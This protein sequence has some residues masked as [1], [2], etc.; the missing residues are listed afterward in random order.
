ME[1]TKSGVGHIVNVDRLKGKRIRLNDFNMTSFEEL[2]AT[3][4]A[5]PPENSFGD[6]PLDAPRPPERYVHYHLNPLFLESLMGS[7]EWSHEDAFKLLF[8][9]AVSSELVDDSQN[10]T[11]I[12]NS[13]RL[14]G[15]QAYVTNELWCRLSQV[16]FGVL[17]L[18]TFCLLVSTWNRK[19]NLD[20]EPNSLATLMQTLSQSPAL[21]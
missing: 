13:T 1:M 8:A 2:I 20:G 11:T 18:L 19:C 12:I 5:S 4:R 15:T 3:G 7:F 10:L 21:R 6:F 17:S 14:Y 9:L 16:G